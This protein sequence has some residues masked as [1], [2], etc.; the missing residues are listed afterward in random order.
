[1]ATQESGGQRGQRQEAGNDNGSKS[2][3]GQRGRRQEAGNDHSR[4]NKSHDEAASGDSNPGKK[5]NDLEKSQ[6]DMGG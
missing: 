2:S 6:K 3:K 4:K 5:N 1:M